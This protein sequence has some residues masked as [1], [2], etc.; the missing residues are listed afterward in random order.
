MISTASD[1]NLTGGT[2]SYVYKGLTK[3][4]EKCPSAKV[5]FITNNTST[6]YEKNFVKFDNYK[7]YNWGKDNASIFKNDYSAHGYYDNVFRDLMNNGV[8]GN[9]PYNS[10]SFSAKR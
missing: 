9:N 5:T 3:L 8:L 6:I 4:L 7:Y 1:G 10:N 2:E